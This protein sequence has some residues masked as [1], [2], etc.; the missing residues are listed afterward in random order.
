MHLKFFKKFHEFSRDLLHHEV[1][2]GVWEEGAHGD[3]AGAL[4]ELEEAARNAVFGHLDADAL[5]Q[6]PAHGLARVDVEA[7]GVR[8]L[9]VGSGVVT[10]ASRVGAT[11]PND[12]EPGPYLHIETTCKR[13]APSLFCS[14]SF[15]KK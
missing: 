14:V 3:V 4:P 9:Q 11:F 2:G 13:V 12:I 6:V 5:V 15:Q 10:G 8:I 7:E 1:D